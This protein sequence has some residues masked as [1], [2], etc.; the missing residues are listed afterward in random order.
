MLGH[1][2][3]GDYELFTNPNGTGYIEKSQGNFIY[4]QT[5][6][7][8]ANE[9]LPVNIERTYNSQASMVSSLGLGWNHNY[10]VELLNIN[11]TAE[12]IDRKAFRDESGTIFLFERLK[13]GTY[14][15]SMGKYITLKAEDK[16]ETVEI[17]AK[18]GNDKTSVEVESSYTM[19]T[20]D[21]LEYRFNSGGQLIY[22]K[23]PNGNFVLL[24]YDGQTGRLLS[25]TTNQN[26]V[27]TFSYKAG[28]KKKADQIVEKALEGLGDKALEFPQ[29]NKEKSPA[30]EEEL[31]PEAAIEMEALGK[32]QVGGSE[33]TVADALENLLLVRKIT[34]PDG[35][36]ID[37]TYD[38]EN[39]LIQAKRSD[40]RENGE[41]I[42]YQYAY[43]GSGQ[44]SMIKDA[45]GNPYKLTYQGK[46][47]K[48]V[49]YPSVEGNQESIRFTYADIQEG[50]I[51]YATTI[52]RGL[53]GAYGVGE[54]VKANRLGSIVYKKDVRGIE[55]HYRYRDNL[56]EKADTEMDYQ[57]LVEGEI[58]TKTEIKSI[59]SAYNEDKNMT[60]E[61]TSDGTGLFF[62]YASQENELVAHQPTRV[63]EEMDG[64]ADLD[65][66]Y[67][68]DEY[69]NEISE[70]NKLSGSKVHTSYFDSGSLFA[71]EIKETVE[72][73]KIADAEGTEKTETIKTSYQY[74][75]NKETGEKT[76]TIVRNDNGK[77]DTVKNRYDLMGK[78]IFSDDASGNTVTYTYDYLGR[79]IST[80]Y[81]DNGK[82]SS[83]E[84]VFDQNGALVK[85][86]D[87]AGEETTYT[88]DAVNRLTNKTVAKGDMSRSYKTAYDFEWSSSDENK[89]ELLYD[90]ISTSP[91]GTISHCY[92]N[93][94]GWEIKECA[95][96]LIKK[97]EYDR[98]G[99][100]IVV[101]MTSM[102]EKGS[103]A[104]RV[105]IYD[106]KGRETFVVLKP[107][108]DSEEKV[109]KVAEDS[110]VNRYTYDNYGNRL[111]STDGNGNTIA[112]QYDEESQLIGIDLD[113]ETD[114][115]TK[116]E[117]GIIETDG[118]ISR[119]TI[120]ANGNVSKEYSDTNGRLLKVVDFGNGK[121]TPISTSYQYNENDDLVQETYSNGDY[122]IY[123]YDDENNLKNVISYQAG[124]KELVTKYTYSH[125]GQVLTMED[126]RIIA[127]KEE[128]Y[129]YTA[130][131]YDELGQLIEFAEFSGSSKPS[132][133]ELSKYRIKYSYDLDGRQTEVRY[134]QSHSEV[135]GLERVY[136]THGRLTEIYAI[137]EG[138]KKNL[139]RSYEYE[140]TGELREVKDFKHFAKGNIKEYTSKKYF[141]DDFLRT[142]R[143]EYTDSNQPDIVRE[144]YDYTYD[145]TSRIVTEKIYYD[146]PEQAEDKR[147]ELRTYEY[148]NLGRLKSTVIID[149]KTSEKIQR[150]Y[151][152]DKVGNRLKM[153]QN[154]EATTYKYNSLNQMT[155][156]QKSQNGNIV[157]DISYEYD[158]NGNLI[159]EED[160][161]TNLI[162][163]SKYDA[164]SQLEKQVVSVNGEIQYTQTNQYN[165]NGQRIRKS[166]N[167]EVTDY[168]YQGETVYST[169]DKNGDLLSFNLLEFENSVIATER[170][171]DGK[172]GIYYF[173]HK[174]VR[175][176]SSAILSP[177]DIAVVSYSYG[178]FGETEM[179]GDPDFYNEVCYA[180]GIY[181]KNTGLYYLNARYY[182][183]ENGRFIS[184]DTKR[185]SIDDPNTWH[186]YA[187]CAND[188]I[189]MVD[190]NGHAAA[191]FTYVMLGVL[192][193][194]TAVYVRYLTIKLLQEFYT[195]WRD[196][197]KYSVASLARALGGVAGPFDWIQNKADAIAKQL[198]ASFAKAKTKPR[199]RKDHEKHHIVAQGAN[200]TKSEEA[201][202]VLTKCGI[203]YKTDKRNLILIQTGLHRRLHTN[204]YYSFVN[205]LVINAYNK[206][207]T[208]NRK[209]NN[210][211]AAILGVVSTLKYLKIFI[212]NL[213]NASPW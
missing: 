129:R 89:R 128:L 85:E 27:T 78:L 46:K 8:I 122:R 17:P 42:S 23:E 70:L 58:V 22:L 38:E 182:D 178:D 114:N 61:K 53:N 166:E 74:S 64:E 110:I 94:L 28:A 136:D 141:Y 160:R 155:S 138:N 180:G 35:T 76:E 44:L 60:S 37:Y 67:E 153:T 111:T 124:N 116:F 186:L 95:N 13:D 56:L 29:K 151:D 21:N 10:D 2:I 168:Y 203:K 142:I 134:P 109:W 201:R 152:Y 183:P 200:R 36:C 170:S 169:T 100:P 207:L 30:D 102:Q 6:A 63:M 190:Y 191:T 205:P 49:F 113:N 150:T 127:S 131:G 81:S 33:V 187:Y 112:L 176:S 55:S 65:F 146:Y 14:A 198:R 175:G 66:F 135:A 1:K 68:Y 161:K 105:S 48:E 130:Y 108:Y 189:N 213:D 107:D 80:H 72:I 106:N 115:L 87:E 212:R 194:I 196:I 16:K 118:S 12:L 79:E 147:D 158:L 104:V 45:K 165:G 92:I 123:E 71:G 77:I 34:L 193:I 177:E 119:K 4:D 164:E 90:T 185:E 39:H 18:N 133:K 121:I 211:K 86:K 91:G 179:M 174:D 83:A 101:Q 154:D 82:I 148:D 52:Q 163:K 11:E 188:P 15:S 59:E 159:K 117:H 31:I 43:N 156:S 40:G 173:Y 126:Y 54:L 197:R 97:T 137:M 51:V 32:T 144:S 140:L 41:C 84:R 93:Q 184:Q 162:V 24:A 69:G 208:L 9:K 195:R 157:N 57:E 26:L 25:A 62:E 120:D 98:N 99:K 145:K 172:S 88:F 125:T 192:F 19:L 202:Q 20:K 50:E 3:Y 210:I 132:E 96:G 103:K 47:V 167:E 143:I 75:Y 181:D 204:L 149:E 139:L 209:K 171:D 73:I 199:Y 7:V 5:D 206:G